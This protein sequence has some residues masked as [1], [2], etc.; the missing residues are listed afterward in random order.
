MSPTDAARRTML[1]LANRKLPPTPTNYARVYGALAGGGVMTAAEAR[2]A[3]LRADAGSR[4]CRGAPPGHPRQ[5][6]A[7]GR[8]HSRGRAARVLRTCPV[9]RRRPSCRAGSGQD[10]EP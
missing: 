9:E 1:E 8:S 7:L 4:R 6:L 5:R 3:A 2:R 10:G